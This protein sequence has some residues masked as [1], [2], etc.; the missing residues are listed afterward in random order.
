MSVVYN[1]R[2]NWQTLRH[3]SVMTDR[4]PRFVPVS[5]IHAI[6]TAVKQRKRLERASIDLF[7]S[8]GFQYISL[9]EK[10]KIEIVG[11]FLLSDIRILDE[12]PT[13][14][15]P[16]RPHEQQQRQQQ[17]RQQQQDPEKHKNVQG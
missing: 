12:L 1:G 3:V 11:P 4:L 16:H 15:A 13:S 8:R 9:A 5:I 2:E 10:N 14:A 7:V 17:Q 6:F